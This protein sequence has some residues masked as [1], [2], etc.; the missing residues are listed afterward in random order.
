MGNVRAM[1]EARRRRQ[2]KRTRRE[3]RRATRRRQ[4]PGES[5][6]RILDEAKRWDD[7]DDETWAV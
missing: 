2:A 5:R 6:Q 3:A 4:T 1:N 7:E